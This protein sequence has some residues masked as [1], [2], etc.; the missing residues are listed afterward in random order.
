[1]TATRRSRRR[2]SRG[3]R[4]PHLGKVRRVLQDRWPGLRGMWR[5]RFR[6]ARSR[7]LLVVAGAILLWLLT[8]TDGPPRQPDDLCSIF[9]QR[10]SWYKA[11]KRSREE[12]GVPEALLLSVV[13]QESG[14]RARV[15]PPRRRFLWI[16]P[17][18]RP[19]SAFGY[20]QVV[21][22]TWDGYRRDTGHGRAE[23]DD[24]ADVMHFIGWYGDQI[25]RQ[26]GIA[27]DDAYHL[28]LAYHEGPTG[29]LRGSHRSK[30]WLLDTAR[31]VATWTERYQRQYDGCREDL[32][33]WWRF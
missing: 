28:Y 14:F 32:G 29:F 11:A 4:R 19:S 22:S 8:W 6:K 18:S 12:W 1:M 10:R 13:R 2:R 9:D 21:R 3:R 25:H 30:A 24:F 17:G 7:A 20:G 31:R 33:R 26:T 15:R 16:F 23:R 27:K 5:R